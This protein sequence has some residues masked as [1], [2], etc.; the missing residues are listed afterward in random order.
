MWIFLSSKLEKYLEKALFVLPICRFVQL[1][2]IMGEKNVL[3]FDLR[4]ANI[5][6]MLSTLV[7]VFFYIRV[8]YCVKVYLFY[9]IAARHIKI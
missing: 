4:I 3:L 9:L 2:D 1:A 5:I 6:L 7:V 8:L